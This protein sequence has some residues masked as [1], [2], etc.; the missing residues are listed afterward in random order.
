MRVGHLG[1]GCLA[2]RRWVG[3][4]TGAGRARP[5]RHDSTGGPRPPRDAGPGATCP[6]ARRT[7]Q[8]DVPAASRGYSPTDE[9]RRQRRRQTGVAHLPLDRRDVVGHAAPGDPVGL[10]LPDEVRRVRVAV[11]RLPDAPGV[12]ERSPA[13]QLQRRI[14]P[15]AD[16][17]E[18][19]LVLD[20]GDGHVGVPMEP[21][22]RPLGEHPEVRECDVPR[23][24]VLPE[25]IAVA[26]MHQ[27]AGPLG[28]PDPGAPTSHSTVV[29]AMAPS[30]PLHGAA[31]LG[32]EPVDLGAATGR[33]VVVSADARRADL[34]QPLHHRVRLRAV[35]DDVA[36]LPDRVDRA[37]R[38]RAPHPVPCRLA[39]MSEST[40]IR[41]GSG[42]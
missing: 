12:H 21:D 29:G 1:L 28:R 22:M 36:E 4:T 15:P 17:R 16:D 2:V 35:A 7:V 19:V 5:F 13:R 37:Q 30:G 20:E 24:H 33:G 11:P 31:S 18:A 40:A 42:A 9:P 8:S 14:G 25:G 26:A 27:V 34:A 23:R 10:R 41:M 3:L 39:W 6:A 32:V 38:P